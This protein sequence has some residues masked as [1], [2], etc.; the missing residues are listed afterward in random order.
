MPPTRGK[1]GDRRVTKD[2]TGQMDPDVPGSS[3]LCVSI[4]TRSPRPFSS[5]ASLVR[6]PTAATRPSSPDQHPQTRRGLGHSTKQRTE[7]IGSLE[8]EETYWLHPWQQGL[9]PT[10]N[11]KNVKYAKLLW[12][13]DLLLISG[14][15]GEDQCR[16]WGKVFSPGKETDLG[17]NFILPAFGWAV[18]DCDIGRAA[19]ILWSWGHMWVSDSQCLGCRG[20]ENHKHLDATAGPLD[21][22]TKVPITSAILVMK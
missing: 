17:R 15:W 22:Q 10:M 2:A 4:G 12:I 6:D 9:L 14:I 5:W 20:V 1:T 7:Q 21:E 19:A 11:P 8:N 16:V 13:Q 3:S 18:R